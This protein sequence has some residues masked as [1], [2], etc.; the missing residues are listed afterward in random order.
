[1]RL[2][3]WSTVLFYKGLEATSQGR[4]QD[5]RNGGFRFAERGSIWS[6][7]PI[8]PKNPH[9][10]KI[11]WTKRGVRSATASSGTQTCDSMNLTSEHTLTCS[12]VR[13][14]DLWHYNH[15]L[16]S[17]ILGM[18]SHTLSAP[19]SY[20]RVTFCKLSATV[21]YGELFAHYQ[22]LSY[23]VD[24]LQ[25]LYVG[26]S[27]HYQL[28]S[29][30]VLHIIGHCSIWWMFCTL[31]ATVLY[32]DVFHIINY[33][34]SHWQ[35]RYSNY[36]NLKNWYY[37]IWWNLLPYLGDNFAEAPKPNFWIIQIEMLRFPLNLRTN[38]RVKFTHIQMSHKVN[39]PTLHD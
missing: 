37:P 3:H 12:S 27:A 1:M 9:E 5:F 26:L 39:I 7:Y 35:L 28:L 32:G 13:K 6:I 25:I 34:P 8:F 19:L 33:C 10:N 24:F 14:G 2:V 20:L 31:L 11:I 21:L 4:I 38:S 29:Y 18:T 16:S 15:I 17:I 30:N 23:V 22:L 36:V